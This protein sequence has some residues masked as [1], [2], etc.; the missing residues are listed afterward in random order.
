[1]TIRNDLLSGGVAALIASGAAGA[2][3][4]AVDNPAYFS[5]STLLRLFREG[6][7]SPVDV[8]ERQIARIEAVNTKVNG[9]SAKHYDAARAAARESEERY[10]A[11]CPRPLE[12]ITVGVKDEYSVKGWVVTM[13]SASMADSDPKQADDA[14]IERLRAAGA[15]LHIQTTVPEFYLWVTTASTHGGVTRNP[16][17]L[18]YSPGGSSGGSAA[19]LTAGFATLA[20]GSDMGGSIRIPASLNG[21]YGFKPPFG[22][23]PTSETAYESGGPLARTFDDLNLLTQVISGPHPLN[24]ASI[25]PGLEHPKRYESIDGWKV[26]YDPMPEMSPLDPSVQAAMEQAIQGLRDIGVAVERVDLGFSVSDW[27]TY[28]LGLGSSSLGALLP[29][30]G[31]DMS[32][33]SPYVSYLSGEMAGAVGPRALVATDALASRYHASVQEKVFSRGFQ[34]LITPALATPFLPANHGMNPRVDTVLIGDT[35][36]S[37]LGFNPNWVWNLLNRYPVVVVPIGQGPNKIPIGMQIVG[38]T[39]DDLAAFSLASAWS[40]AAPQFFTG[41]AFPDFRHHV[42]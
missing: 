28:L 22:R 20:L 40:Q 31:M 3:D 8:L 18:A 24:H 30:D 1:M 19:A 42:D 5:A 6:N 29:D 13:G 32:K 38:N 12:G 10:K 7:L 23:V 27:P 26:A 39:F 35:P 33:V 9:I 14:V 21:L 15:I 25:R 2:A 11:G 41:D 4:K 34:A 17:N 16:W 36:V 37:G